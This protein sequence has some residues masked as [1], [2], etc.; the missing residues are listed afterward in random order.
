MILA[1]KLVKLRKQNGLTQLELAEKMNVT[2]QAVS[3]WEVG[4]AIPSMEN[5]QALAKLYAISVDCLLDDTSDTRKTSGEAVATEDSPDDMVVE[6]NLSTEMKIPASRNKTTLF[7]DRRKQQHIVVILAIFVLLSILMY[8]FVKPLRQDNDSENP[9][10]FSN[11]DT[12]RNDYPTE[13][14]PLEW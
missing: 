14:F 1:E 11:L 4:A 3:R 10:P 8:S 2:R 7:S 5:L 6:D 13:E 12:D 9:T